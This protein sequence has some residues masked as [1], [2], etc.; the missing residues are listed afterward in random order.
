VNK[1]NNSVDN[2]DKK[3]LE[4]L[5]RDCRVPIE[6]IAKEIGLPKSTVQYRIKKMETMGVIKGYHAKIDNSKLGKDFT[7]ITLVRAKYGKKYYDK[8]GRILAKI[9]GTSGIYFVLGDNDFIFICTSDNRE[10][11]MRKLNVFYDSE[12]IERTSTMVVVETIKEESE[13]DF[14]SCKKEIFYKK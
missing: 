5:Q 11:F 3:I 2:I 14:G 12:E 9:P 8:V 1:K 13:L 6:R 10:D 4:R 7:T